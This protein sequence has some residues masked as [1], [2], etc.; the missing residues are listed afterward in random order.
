MHLDTVMTMVDRDAITAYPNVIDGARVWKLR[1]AD[2]PQQVVAREHP[3]RVRSQEV[4]QAH[5]DA[6][7]KQ[8]QSL[9]QS[10]IRKLT[11]ELPG[12]GI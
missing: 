7:D 6:S 8:Y 1:P 12:G 10:V 4:Q 3:T 11:I 9:I 5:L 2:T